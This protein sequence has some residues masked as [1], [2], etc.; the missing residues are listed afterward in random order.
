MELILR[1]FDKEEWSVYATIRCFIILLVF[2]LFKQKLD[3]QLLIISSFIGMMDGDL[4]TQMAFILFLSI[5]LTNTSK[6]W[7]H[8]TLLL[9]LTGF[10]TYYIPYYNFIQSFIL[11]NIGILMLFRFLIIGWFIYIIYLIYKNKYS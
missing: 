2:I 7:I 11:N 6:K 1:F 4:V 9:L 5:L 10:I 8:K 3:L